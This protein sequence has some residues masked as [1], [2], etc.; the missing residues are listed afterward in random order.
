MCFARTVEASANTVVVIRTLVGRPST[1]MQSDAV[2]DVSLRRVSGKLHEPEVWEDRAK[3]FNEVFCQEFQL[4]E[5][6]SISVSRLPVLVLHS[7]MPRQRGIPRDFLGWTKFSNTP[8][9]SVWV[10][11]NGVKSKNVFC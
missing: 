4:P 7:C 3:Y 2:Q 6:C 10:F 11:G 8:S 1:E 9:S 5:E